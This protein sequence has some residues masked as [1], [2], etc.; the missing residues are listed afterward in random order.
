MTK[1]N[2]KP[3]SVNQ[4]WGGRT[5]KSKLYKKYEANMNHLLPKGVKVPKTG[6]IA[7]EVHFGLS[8]KA[9]DIDNPL[10]TT[11]DC[12]QRKYGFNDK[13]IYELHIKKFDVKRGEEFIK[14][15]IN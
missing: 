1:I 9:S 15:E 7:L 14:F 5:F 12:L 10:K 8:S 11:I 4:A 6:K 3:L 13:Q 2:I